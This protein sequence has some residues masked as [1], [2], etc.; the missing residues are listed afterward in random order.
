MSTDRQEIKVYIYLR[1]SQTYIY[2]LS[3]KQVGHLRAVALSTQHL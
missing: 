1:I 3:I 2:M